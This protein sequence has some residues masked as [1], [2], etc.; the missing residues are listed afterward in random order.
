MGTLLV[1]G[2]ILTL[3]ATVLFEIRWTRVFEAMALQV[4]KA[5]PVARA[6]GVKAGGIAVEFGRDTARWSGQRIAS[7]AGAA[8]VQGGV[9]RKKS[10]EVLQRMG[11]SLMRQEGDYSTDVEWIEVSGVHEKTLVADQFPVSDASDRTVAAQVSPV[12]EVQWEPTVANPT[13]GEK[14]IL[15]MFA[16][17]SP[18]SVQRASATEAL[19]D[20]FE[21]D[22]DDTQASENDPPTMP[23]AA[24]DNWQQRAAPSPQSQPFLL[25]IPVT[26]AESEVSQLERTPVMVERTA[27]PSPPAP[28]VSPP[29]SPGLSNRPPEN[30]SF[31]VDRPS[32]SGNQNR[33]NRESR[34]KGP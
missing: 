9:F 29:T 26:G 19:Y 34:G 16:E 15:D 28:V 5:T 1:I 30:E 7:G 14:S 18:R 8:A 23:A 3:S 13:K 17:V 6:A 11:R 21:G 12:A 32:N 31:P 25:G 2:T 4:D 10:W 24:A 33:G 20:D 22:P 27:A